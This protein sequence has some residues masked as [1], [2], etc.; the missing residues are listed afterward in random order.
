MS[1]QGKTGRY[2]FGK[3]VLT[4]KCCDDICGPFDGHNCTDCQEFD[5]I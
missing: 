1:K 4:C 3:K 2:Y 5:R